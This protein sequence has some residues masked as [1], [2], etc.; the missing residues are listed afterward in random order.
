MGRLPVVD[1]DGKLVGI[2]SIDDLLL[3]CEQPEDVVDA[4]KSIWKDRSPE[5]AHEPAELVAAGHASGGG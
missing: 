4:A 5:H 3:H 2:L 1:D